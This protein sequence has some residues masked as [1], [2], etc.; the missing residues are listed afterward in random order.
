MKQ[1]CVCSVMSNSLQPHGLQPARLLCLWDFLGK[2][3]GVDF[4]FLLQ[5]IF[6]TQGQNPISCIA[7]NSLPP[8]H[9]RSPFINFSGKNLSKSIMFYISILFC[10]QMQKLNNLKTCL[11]HSLC[12]SHLCLLFICIYQIEMSRL[13]FTYV[14][15]E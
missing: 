6:P 4:H 14:S 3:T 7:S 8:S 15:Y 13:M 2:N 5:G 1:S 11:E 10:Y 12:Y 9:Q